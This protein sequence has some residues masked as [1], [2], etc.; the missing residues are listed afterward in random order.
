MAETVLQ[1][2]P[3]HD[4]PYPTMPIALAYPAVVGYQDHLIVVGGCNSYKDRVP[5]VNIL[6]ITGK[7]WNSS[8]SF[9]T[10]LLDR[11]HI[12]LTEDSVYLVGRQRVILQASIFRLLS[13]AKSGVWRIIYTLAMTTHLLSLL[14]TPS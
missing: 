6:D 14:A 1:Y 7:K 11:Y 13:G 3:G 2:T 10:C 12:V 9:Y 4:L 8:Q 5:N